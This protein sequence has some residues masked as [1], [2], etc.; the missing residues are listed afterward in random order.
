ML[1]TLSFY[2]ILTYDECIEDGQNKRGRSAL[3]AERG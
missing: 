2:G 1:N 3:D